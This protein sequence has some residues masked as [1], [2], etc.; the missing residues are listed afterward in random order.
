MNLGKRAA[1]RR[2]VE[3]DR[4]AR[5]RRIACF[6]PELT[7]YRKTGVAPLA[8]TPPVEPHPFFP[9]SSMSNGEARRWLRSYVK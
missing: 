2:G 7:G 4:V 8:G 5:E 1:V 3:H 9:Y 6:Q